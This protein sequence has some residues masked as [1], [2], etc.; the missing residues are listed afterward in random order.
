M[1]Y[2][3]LKTIKDAYIDDLASNGNTGKAAELSARSQ[4]EPIFSGY[5]VHPESEPSLMELNDA[6][7]DIHLDLMA[8]HKEISHSAEQYKDLLESAKRRL[9]NVNSKVLIEEERIKDLNAICGNYDEFSSVVTLTSD[10]LNGSFSSYDKRTFCCRGAIKAI[11]PIIM[12]VEGNGYE[13]NAYVYS[14]GKY[15][16]DSV[17]TKNRDYMIDNSLSTA[18]EYSR[19]TMDR[20]ETVYPP[21]A[22]FDIQEAR[23]SIVIAAQDRFTSF[24]LTSDMDN[25]II[26]DI[27]TSHD[28]GVSF[29]SV[30]R[31]KE[32]QV[33][34]MDD[35]Y[36]N[37]SYAYGSGVI[38]F[39]G[40]QWLKLVLRSGGSTSDRLAF[41]WKDA[42]LSTPEKSV[43]VTK[44][45]PT[46]K[47]HVIRINN[48]ELFSGQ[49]EHSNSITT[50]ELIDTP[51]SSLA[52]FANE[53]IPEQ[54]ESQYVYCQYI[55][56]VNGLDYS[57]VPINCDR[58]NG[59]K[60]IR[61]QGHTS[62]DSYVKGI[63]EPIKTARLTVKIYTE[64]KAYTPY[65]SNLK[66]C[67]GKEVAK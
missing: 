67:Y 56:T 28:S 9:E 41:E 66:I 15:V 12:T 44:E 52:I 10:D 58:D 29:Q 4:E 57:V 16:S 54:F 46:A 5:S 32:L 62:Q 51:V 65:L 6:L 63:L 14:G 7:N 13:G 18:W 1:A 55:L 47:R 27:L 38:S 39:P 45:L 26:E 23:C 3:G 31:T 49:Y 37:D 35:K 20:S 17:S 21:A 61:F 8:V 40:T 48:I 11:D 60:V 33:N 50:G 25:I 22:N 42:N 64:D 2:I 43:V 53:Y 59:Y 19:I 24:A 30:M 34:N 36:I